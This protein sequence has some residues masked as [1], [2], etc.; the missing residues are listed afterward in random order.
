ME[1]P[2]RKK[3]AI[4]PHTCLV[5]GA[6]GGVGLFAVQL[7]SRAGAR[8]AGV[9]GN[10]EKEALVRRLG[11]SEVVPRIE[12]AHGPF[13]LVLESV[14]GLSLTG[15]LRQAARDGTVVVFGS[16]SPEPST[17]SF[18]D[19]AGRAH[20]TIYGFFVYESGEPPTFGEDLGYLASLVAGGEL[21]PG[22]G[23]QGPWTD[24]PAALAA[25]RNRQVAGKVVLTVD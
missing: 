14:G 3:R 16:S 22:L 21:D 4:L 12:D 23:W 17:I 18:S 6:S 9:V 5:T 1:S 10:P 7:A 11:A 8:V 13:H 25:L 2:T 19:F 24:L 20:A 15:A